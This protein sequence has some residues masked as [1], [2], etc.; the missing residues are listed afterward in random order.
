MDRHGGPA[1]ENEEVLGGI[2]FRLP[3]CGLGVKFRIGFIRTLIQSPMIPMKMF[4]RNS[5][6]FTGTV[7][8]FVLFLI[9][10]RPEAAAQDFA[11]LWQLGNANGV[12]T[13]FSQEMGMNTAPG[14][15]V[16]QD[17]DYYFAGQYPPPIGSVLVDEV[18]VNFDRA[19]VPGDP[20]NRLHFN[21]TNVHAD[22][23][24]QLRVTAQLCCIG[25]A[26]GIVSTH[27]VVFRF[28]GQ[29]FFEQSQITA[30][31]LVEETATAAELGA[32]EGA[33][34]IE[35]QRTGGSDSS[36]IQ[37]DYIRL[38]YLAV[39][40]DGDGIPDRYE[41]LYGFLDPADPTDAANDEDGD[42]LS[43]LGEFLAGTDP[44]NPDTDGDTL[45]DGREVNETG[46]NP[47]LADTD[48]DAL[49]DA[50]EVDVYMT[51][52][53][54]PD[55]D[56][57]TLTDAE[58]VNVY[59]TSPLL[60]DTDTDGVD[61]PIEIELGTDPTDPEDVPVIF[62]ALWQLGTDDGAT[63]PF[64][65]EVG[66]SPPAPGS[67]EQLDDDYYFAGTYPDPIG[68]LA[69]DENL[70]NFE[71]A[72]T[73]G[74]TFSRIHFNLD[75]IEASAGAEY[76][77]WLDL[78]CL[79]SGGG[80]SVHDVLVRFNGHEIFAQQGIAADALLQMIA[81]GNEVEAVVGANVIE[82]E[83]TGGSE[84]AW[85]QFDRI[86][87]EF[88]AEDNDRDG[89]PNSYEAK[90][91]F[92]DP[93]NPA[94]AAEDEDSDGLT[95]LEEFLNG[96]EPA[97]ADTDEDGLTDGAEVKTHGTN[98]RVA[99]TDGDGLLD[100]PEVNTHGTNPL[101]VDSDGD[102]LWDGDEL[103]EGTNPLDPDTDG[104]G[105]TDHEEVLYGTNPLDA[106]SVPLPYELLWQV[107]EDNGNQSEFTQEVGGSP[108]A[109]GSPNMLDDDYY[110][111]GEYP[112]PIGVVAEDEEW[113]NF[114][115]ALTS[116]NFFSRI[117]FNLNDEQA[118][119][120]S[121]IRLT[122]DLVQLGAAEAGPSIHDLI[123]RVNGT[124]I[125]NEPGIDA[126]R[127]IRRSF[128]ASDVNA[129]AGANVVEIERTGQSP[130]SWIQ[131]D[132]L[133]AEYRE[134]LTDDP[135]L[136]VQRNA[137][138]GELP[139]GTV[140][141]TVELELLNNGE[142]NTLMLSGAELSGPDA[143]H[144][145]LGAVPDSIEPGGSALLPVTFNAMGRVGG[146][147]AFLDLSSNDISDPV[148][149]VDLS[150]L[151]PN[152]NG[153]VA[154]YRLDETEG[155]F[156]VDSSGRGRHGEYRS[157]DAGM[158]TLGSPSLA[159][160]GTAVSLD[161][162]DVGAGFAEIPDSFEPFVDLSI[163]MWFEV[164]EG[165]DSVL[166]LISKNRT[167][168]QGSPFAV[169]YNAGSLFVFNGGATDLVAAGISAGEPHHAV[170]VFDNS[171]EERSGSLYVDG[172]LV[173]TVEDVD[174]FD[175]AGSSPLVIGALGGSFGFRGV[176]DDVQLYET[177]LS[178]ADVAYLYENPGEELPG[179]VVVDPGA[180]DD[181]DGQSNSAEELAGTDPNDASS[182]FRVSGI[183]RMTDGLEMSWSSVDGKSYSVEYSA[184]ME[185]PSWQSIASVASAGA[186]TTYRD[187]DPGR[188][189]EPA[190][191]YR[192]RVE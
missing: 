156:L 137:V 139:P 23:E 68:V 64:S 105:D 170:V 119:P 9:A 154:R 176:L 182:V 148:I 103:A 2:S 25:A 164:L 22:P 39:D 116:G 34:T 146:F 177:L 16:L 134:V 153:L 52:P 28:N 96:T 144:Y 53:R 14:S 192:I 31:L 178:A 181:G 69:L 83:R 162:G 93:N 99:D 131:F 36:W 121:Q 57:D 58:E 7:F 158:F 147:T 136:R 133:S 17:D 107:G 71:R 150:A 151:I 42:G 41:D 171:S 186:V 84:G 120:S 26:A 43:N 78:C 145:S 155:T 126:D 183:E 94:D 87:A 24:T 54:N 113:I 49:S 132:Y 101:A 189:A 51:D 90:Y 89:L 82:I 115:R 179:E 122:F 19:L 167:G 128:L 127:F 100:G 79:G 117:H 130:N 38:E 62:S 165:A 5:A 149:R 15:P 98:P 6:A 173:G 80:E 75:D 109:P 46:T 159:G 110:F 112:D 21:L 12:Q 55:T 180:D 35:I 129:V 27:D 188:T 185:T 30:D 73:S 66:G 114:E 157:T 143:D 32:R 175:D 20:F 135:N 138:F 44:E 141:R 111:A 191:H 1:G 65:Q 163:A 37:F 86:T 161:H 76:R 74:N 140:S 56:G 8:V 97:R 92:L 11:Q 61:D 33:N 152:A 168:E 10:G 108:P 45:S 40:T 67:A 124:E 85:I 160:P 72:L 47:L 125:L 187:T 59:G 118:S 123:F 166:T 184:T 106:G 50:D 174:G 63:A 91:A 172:E 81:A 95:N 60:A 48:G 88:R 70:V 142:V 169:A 77:I 13:E 18:W 190:G 104:D 3:D 102:G 29:E 4:L